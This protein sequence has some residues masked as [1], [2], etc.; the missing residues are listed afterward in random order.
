MKLEKGGWAG[1]PRLESGGLTALLRSLMSNSNCGK[2]QPN[3]PKTNTNLNSIGGKT[4]NTHTHCKDPVT[5]TH[6]H[7][8]D[9]DT[10]TH[11]HTVKT[12]IHTQS[13]GPAQPKC[14]QRVRGW[15]GWQEEG[16]TANTGLTTSYKKGGWSR[17]LLLSLLCCL[18]KEP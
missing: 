4:E 1:K 7:C 11:T 17:F 8:E 14:W 15:K 10:H 16:M 5:Y 6:T 3:K 12:Q 13:K 18:V 2:W 9:P